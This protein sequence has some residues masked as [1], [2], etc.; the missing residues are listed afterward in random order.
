MPAVNISYEH[1][2][3]EFTVET[4]LHCLC[5]SQHLSIPVTTLVMFIAYIPNGAL[6]ITFNFFIEVIYRV[7]G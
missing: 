3:K 1:K 6:R 7:A 2:Y 5:D 4:T